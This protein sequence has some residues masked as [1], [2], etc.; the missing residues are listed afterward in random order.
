MLWHTIALKGI[1][2]FS[3]IFPW[4][5]DAL[6]SDNRRRAFFVG[7]LSAYT[8][9]GFII[10]LPLA[11]CRF[12]GHLIFDGKFKIKTPLLLFAGVALGMVVT[13]FFPD[14]LSHIFREL[15]TVFERPDFIKA[16]DFFG[17]EWQIPNRLQLQHF[18]GG[19]LLSQ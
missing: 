18:L 15:K 12:A 16:G 6:W 9:V 14:N 13:P 1:T 11:A 17:S 3:I 2:L 10:M 7:L 4:I 19:M 8:Y 5:V